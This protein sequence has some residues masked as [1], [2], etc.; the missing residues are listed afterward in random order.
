MLSEDAKQRLT[1]WFRQWRL[2]LRRFLV[3]RTGVPAADVEDVAQEVFL[4]LMR[5]GDGELV[6]YPQAYLHKVAS[7]VAIEWSTRAR[8]RQPHA[9]RWLTQLVDGAQPDQELERAET[10]AAIDQ[11]LETLTPYQRKVI[12]LRFVDRKSYTEISTE[13]G[14]SVRSVERQIKKSYDKLRDRMDPELLGDI[15]HGSE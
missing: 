12:K 10:L 6:D 11:V 9:A 13:L 2:P 4:R 14:E 1:E 15:T 5:Y 8:N 3:A 7:H